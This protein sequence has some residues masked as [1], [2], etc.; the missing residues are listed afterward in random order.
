MHSP[1]PMPAISTRSP[2]IDVAGL[3]ALS[4]TLH[5]VTRV[6]GFLA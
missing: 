5:G 6:G 4:D 3:S 1:N 2:K